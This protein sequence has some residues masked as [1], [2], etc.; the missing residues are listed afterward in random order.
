LGVVGGKLLTERWFSKE[1]HD[2]WIEAPCAQPCHREVSVQQRK[3][4][5]RTVIKGEL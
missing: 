5:S 1:I 2:G 3:K 4:L